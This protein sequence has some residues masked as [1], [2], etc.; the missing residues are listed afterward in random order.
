MPATPVLRE[1]RVSPRQGLFGTSVQGSQSICVAHCGGRGHPKQVSQA[2]LWGKFQ[3]HRN[4]PLW[5]G[6]NGDLGVAWSAGGCGTPRD[7]SC[8][9]VYPPFTQVGILCPPL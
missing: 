8:P 9:Q 5:T 2:R 3:T 1:T 4:G 7:A 6:L